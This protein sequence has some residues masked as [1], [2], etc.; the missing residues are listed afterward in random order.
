MMTAFLTRHPVAAY[1]VM[2]FTISW[3]AVL[4]RRLDG[5]VF[6]G[7]RLDGIRDPRLKRRHGILAT[8]LIVP[9]SSCSP[10]DSH[11]PRQYGLFLRSSARLAAGSFHD[12]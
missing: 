9:E 4:L 3:G 2:T 10:M 5:R 1:F 11:L 8:G 6:R 12:N 7:A